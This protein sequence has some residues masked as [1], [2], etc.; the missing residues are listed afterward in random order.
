MGNELGNPNSKLGITS[1]AV[2]TPNIETKELEKFLTLLRN[3]STQKQSDVLTKDELQTVLKQVEK[4][5]PPDVELFTQLFVLFDET[6]HDIVDYKNFLAGS[7]VCLLSL[8]LR[9]KLKFGFSVYDSEGA[10]ASLRGDVKRLLLSINQTAAYFGDP[11]LAP[12]DIEA[13]VLQ[14]FKDI[15]SKGAKGIPHNEII[16]YLLQNP[17]IVGFMKGEGNVRFGSA[18]LRV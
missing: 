4:F 9:D 7:A 18:E 17:L 8:P 3:L 12:K 13:L 6:G 16:E 10:N 15:Q 1:L 11:V 14:L 2:T 5:A